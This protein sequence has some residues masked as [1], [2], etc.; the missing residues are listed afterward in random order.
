MTLIK[1]IL[2]LLN[3]AGIGS[4]IEPNNNRN[5]LYDSSF[6][7]FK[8]SILAGQSYMLTQEDDSLGE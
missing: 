4:C 5:N 6:D 7:D 1:A 8:K 3:L 2:L